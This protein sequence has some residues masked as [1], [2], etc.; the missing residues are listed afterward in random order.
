MQL[1]L[2][3]ATRMSELLV[4]FSF[5]IINIYIY[6]GVGIESTTEDD[7]ERLRDATDLIE[8]RERETMPCVC[9]CVRKMLSS[10]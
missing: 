4:F 9:L 8:E 2:V 5:F 10:L 7:C 1:P 3:G 6:M